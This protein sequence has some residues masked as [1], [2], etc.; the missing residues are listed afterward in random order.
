MSGESDN[1]FIGGKLMLVGEGKNRAPDE[2][3]PVHPQ[4]V[5]QEAFLAVFGT[6]HNT[7]VL[8]T[9]GMVA[10][11]SE[12]NQVWMNADFSAAVSCGKTQVSVSP[13]GSVAAAIE[14]GPTISLDLSGEVLIRGGKG[15][16]VTSTGDGAMIRGGTNRTACFADGSVKATAANGNSFGLTPAGEVMVRSGDRS[17]MVTSDGAVLVTENGE[18]VGRFEAPQK[19]S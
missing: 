8:F 17:V 14:G 9:T 5:S 15:P 13:D 3:F 12:M 18:I 11:T 7:H 1:R 19:L 10:I 4:G 2:V 6:G 16:K